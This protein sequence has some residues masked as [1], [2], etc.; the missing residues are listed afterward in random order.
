MSNGDGTS[1]KANATFK[2]NAILK[3]LHIVELRRVLVTVGAG[4]TQQSDLGVSA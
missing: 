4:K 2:A 1:F 3:A